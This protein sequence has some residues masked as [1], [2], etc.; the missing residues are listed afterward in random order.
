MGHPGL[1][2]PGLTGARRPVPGYSHRVD[3]PSFDAST[4]LLVVDVQNDFA[5]PQG[6][7]AVPG[8]PAVV[9][10]C[11]ALVERAV[12][13]GALVVHTQDWHPPETPH[14]T[15]GG[16]D[17]PVHCV[18][19]TWGAELHPGLPVAGPVVRKG[20]DGRDGY[21]GFTVRD[22][23]DPDATEDTGLASLLE[24]HGVRRVVVVGLAADVCVADTALDA[25]QHGLGTVVDWSATAPVELE[26]GDA[27]RTLSRL[28]GAGVEVVHA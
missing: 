6:G 9:E 26:E 12:H 13:A 10:A 8:G 23:Q 18:R 25:V 28:R 21:S 15:T 24:E 22:P 3:V 5:D 7:L 16:G 27:E 1:G 4:A 2:A 14:F 17:W 11:A 20:T 19:D